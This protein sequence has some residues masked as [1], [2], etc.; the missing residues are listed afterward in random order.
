MSLTGISIGVDTGGTHTDLVLAGEGRLL[1][2]KVPSTTDDL[3][4][5]I[6]DGVVA[7][8]REAGVPLSAVS[9]FVYASTFVTNLFIE[10]K[11]APVGL[12]TTDGFRDVLEIGRASRKPDVYDIH[13]RPAKPL[14]PRHLRLGVKE[15]ID[16]RG[17][18]LVPLDEEHARAA[19]RALASTGVG[20]IAVCL[21]HAY[22]NPAH[23]RRIAALAGEVCPGIDVSLSS[24]VVRE[25]REYERS[26]TTCVNAFIKAPIGGHLRSL[27]AALRERGVTAMPAIMQGNGGISRF[28]TAA[29]APTS[30]THSGVMG[31]IVGAGALAAR[32][33]IRDL[34]TL[35]MGGTSADVSLVANGQPTLS[36]RSSI[37]PYPLLAPTLDM[38]T[39]GAGGGSIAWI[40]GGTALRVGPQSAGSMPGPACYG[41]G[42]GAATVTDANLVASRLNAD[43]FLGGARRLDPSLARQAIAQVGEIGRA[44][45]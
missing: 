1:T 8:A 23:E 28:D 3:T 14:V 20:S 22:A 9:R 18:V 31:G 36:H 42:G 11:Q 16:P 39:I 2:L 13:W 4:T 26:S 38:I 41:Q 6:I 45:V 5:G 32:S 15:R 35:D 19:L 21:L 43:Y 30:I 33:G 29:A 27:A 34:I 10:G 7:L 40:D 44:H 17:E 24:D 12:I 25:F 37:G